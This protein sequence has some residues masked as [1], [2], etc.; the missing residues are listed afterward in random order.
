MRKKCCDQYQIQILRPYRANRLFDLAGQQ[1]E[2]IGISP[3]QRLFLRIV[4]FVGDQDNFEFGSVDMPEDRQNEHQL[5][6][7]PTGPIQSQTLAH[8][9]WAGRKLVRQD[10]S[11]FSHQKRVNLP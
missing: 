7:G 6:A 10:M 5:G 1:D 8:T 4:G 2:R 11:V 3:A 9:L